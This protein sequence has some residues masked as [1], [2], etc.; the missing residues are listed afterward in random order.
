MVGFFTAVTRSLDTDAVRKAVADS[1]PPNFLDLNLQAFEKGLEYGTA[2]LTA[3]PNTAM[4]RCR[5]STRRSSVFAV[6][7]F[8]RKVALP[9]VYSYSDSFAVLQR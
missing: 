7:R 9:M 1:V 4:S 8:R 3:H 2:A 6:T 5:R